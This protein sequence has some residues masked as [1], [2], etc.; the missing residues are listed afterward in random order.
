MKT[1]LFYVVTATLLLA[2][3]VGTA[4]AQSTKVEGR[5]T[6]GGKPVVNAEVVLTN[7]GNGKIY[8]MKTDKNGQFGAIGL[9]FGNYDQEVVSASGEKLL[10]RPVR[11]AGAGGEPDNLSV[12]I[13]SGGSAPKLTKEEKEQIEKIKS[14]NAKALSINAIINV[15]QEAVKAQNWAD[16]KT[17]LNQM[18]AAEPGRWDVYQALGDVQG[19]LAEFQD[20]VDSYEK[21]IKAAQDVVAGNGPKASGGSPAPDPAKAKLGIAQ[22]LG[23]QGNAYAK[24]NKQPEAIAALTKA[25][26]MDPNPGTA[27]FNLCAVQYNAGNVQ[28]ANAAC[29]KAIAVDPNR[30]DTYFIKGSAMIGMSDGKL[31]SGGHMI[32]PPGTKEALNKYLELAPNGGHANDVKAMLNE[33][34][35]KIETSFKDKSGKKK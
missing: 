35:A 31:D 1:R 5:I 6:D 22:M 11:L 7:Q 18:L 14:E 27:F 33:L 19:K 8:K 28:A 24:L 26:E 4:W 21:G 12:D 15:Y 13:S 29:D 32:V 2:M 17:A 20:S 30:A 25:A 3:A 16:A 34:G 23:A 9:D 10:K